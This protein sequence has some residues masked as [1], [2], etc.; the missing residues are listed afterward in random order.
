MLLS[1]TCITLLVWCLAPTF[2]KDRE[3]STW[4]KMEALRTGESV[5]VDTAQARQSGML[6]TIGRDAITF[7]SN[8]D[9]LITILRADVTR[10]YTG[11]RSNRM[12]NLL[13][14]VAAG[15]AV[16]AVLYGTLGQFYRNETGDEPGLL[17]IPIG[18]GT[19]AGAVLPTGGWKKVYENTP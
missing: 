13:I 7:R 9:Q 5:R 6:E 16:G 2:A 4:E 3:N 12:R 15:A 1:R 19:A 10:V 18:V 11:S 14:G 8:K 17:V